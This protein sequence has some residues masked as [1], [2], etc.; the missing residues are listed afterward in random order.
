MTQQ[1]SSDCIFCRIVAGDVPADLVAESERSVA[2]RDIRPHAPV[3]LLVVPKRHEP[4]I[5]ALAAASADDLSDAFALVARVAEQEGIAEH[6]RIVANTGSG[7]GQ[8]V[9]HAHLHVLGG[10]SFTDL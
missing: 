6:H 9:F 8:T 7:A 10:R 1:T 3:H 4:N 2:F 5:G